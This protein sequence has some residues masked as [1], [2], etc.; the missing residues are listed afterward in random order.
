MFGQGRR[1]ADCDGSLAPDASLEWIRA[2]AQTQHR[3]TARTEVT[4]ATKRI[5]RVTADRPAGLS[6]TRWVNRCR[7]SA[8]FRPRQLSPCF[9]ATMAYSRIALLSINT[10]NGYT[11]AGSG[12]S[13]KGLELTELS[14][15]GHVFSWQRNLDGLG[16]RVF[17]A[18]NEALHG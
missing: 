11:L 9:I 3:W 4:S 17:S 14:S 15:S 7:V 12:T 5:E 18:G 8:G 10:N 1:P 6:I 2:R 16:S 13:R